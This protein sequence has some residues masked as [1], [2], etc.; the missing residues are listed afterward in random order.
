M[1]WFFQ[2]EPKLRRISKLPHEF[3]HGHH[4]NDDPR[5]RR[6]HGDQPDGFSS[7]GCLTRSPWPACCGK[8]ATDSTR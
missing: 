5:K 1:E 7:A 8:S 4:A 3:Q 6:A 2:V